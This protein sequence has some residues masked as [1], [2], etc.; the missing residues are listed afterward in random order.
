MGLSI[1]YSLSLPGSHTETP[2]D[3]RWYFWT[4]VDAFSGE[5]SALLEAAMREAKSLGFEATYRDESK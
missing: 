5:E 2:Y 3:G 4:F 1:F